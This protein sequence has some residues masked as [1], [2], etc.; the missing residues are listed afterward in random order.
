MSRR[1]QQFK[2]TS[3]L[4]VEDE[5]IIVAFAMCPFFFMDH[6]KGCRLELRGSIHFPAYYEKRIGLQRIMKCRPHQHAN[7]STSRT[8][9]DFLKLL[10]MQKKLY[11]A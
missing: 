9:K 5:G 3:P 1:T 10:K 6:C 4:T 11:G 8:V 2:V 7:T